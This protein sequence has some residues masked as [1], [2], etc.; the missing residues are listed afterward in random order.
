MVEGG[1]GKKN[2]DRAI[3]A[4]CEKKGVERLIQLGVWI[5]VAHSGGQTNQ[6]LAKHAAFRRHL[7][8]LARNRIRDTE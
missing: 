5:W 1:R 7:S 3:R 2:D 8:S 6:S 4:I